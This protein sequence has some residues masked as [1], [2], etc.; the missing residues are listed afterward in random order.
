MIR[1]GVQFGF[2]IIICYVGFRFAEFAGQLEKGML[3]LVDR[4]PGVEMFLPI[5]ALVSLKY[6]IF[7]GIINDVH[8]SGFFQR[9]THILDEVLDKKTRVEITGRDPSTQVVDR[10]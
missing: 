1:R 2:L 6:F 9:Y 4:P 3:P 10:P 8:P 7:T 5:S